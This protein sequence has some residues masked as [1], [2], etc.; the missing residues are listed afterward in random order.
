LE[1]IVLNIFRRNFGWL[2]LTLLLTWYLGL[3]AQAQTAE[4]NKK[5]LTLD[6]A[7][8]FALKHYPAVRASLERSAA[9]QAGVRLD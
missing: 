4:A 2:A 9:A 6:E 1:R 7:V 3:N 8:D 5:T